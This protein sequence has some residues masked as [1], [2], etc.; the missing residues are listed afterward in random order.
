MNAARSMIGRP[1]FIP[2]LI[3]LFFMFAAGFLA[4]KEYLH[5]VNVAARATYEAGWSKVLPYERNPLS[6]IST[7]Y[8]WD[9][10]HPGA[11]CMEVYRYFH[12]E[13]APDFR[14][15]LASAGLAALSF[16]AVFMLPGKKPE[17]PVE[18]SLAKERD[19][20][21]HGYLG[22]GR[23]GEGAVFLGLWEGKPKKYVQ[24][25]P[26]ELARHV[27]VEAG[28]GE[29]KTTTYVMSLAM[30]AARNKQG[31]I[32][33]D[34]KYGEPSGLVDV[35][36]IFRYY[37]R[38]VYTY[39]PYDPD[40]PRI[41]LLDMVTDH[42]S[43]TKLAE[44]LIAPAED[45]SVD[46]YRG[47]ERDMFAAVALAIALT[48]RADGR[49]ARMSE[50]VKIFNTGDLKYVSEILQEGSRFSTEPKNDPW[51]WGQLI[52]NDEKRLRQVPESMRSLRTKL[53]VFLQDP[54]V[55]RATSRGPRGE[56][57]SLSAIFEDP[58]LLYIGLPKTEVVSETNK[59][60]MRMLKI[61]IDDGLYQ[62]AVENHGGELPYL[63]HYVLDEFQN[64]GELPRIFEALALF[65]SMRTSFHII[66]QDRAAVE[67][68]YG[69][70]GL[71]QLI[72]N[73][74]GTK[75]YYVGGLSDDARMELEERVGEKVIVEEGLMRKLSPTHELEARQTRRLGKKPVYS[76]EEMQRATQGTVLARL[77]YVPYVLYHAVLLDDPQHPLYRDWRS[78]KESAPLQA[79][80]WL[81][82]IEGVAVEG[83]NNARPKDSQLDRFTAWVLELLDAAAPLETVRARDGNLGMVRVIG[84][85][86]EALAD[87]W[88]ERGW[89]ARYRENW[90]ITRKGIE[91]LDSGIE[92]KIRGL[93][94]IRRQL[95]ALEDM[96]EVARGVVA[97]DN[98]RV[99][100][101]EPSRTIFVHVSTPLANK[102]EE[103][104]ADLLALGVKKP[105]EWR[106]LPRGRLAYG[107]IHE[108]LLQRGYGELFARNE[109]GGVSAR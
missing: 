11:N 99:I 10:K 32:A 28:T 58:S 96:G 18:G 108:D 29:G 93:S 12:Q 71:E 47:V 20:K 24:L 67:K 52:F 5:S 48:A 17:L 94:A 53:A 27:L 14:L 73:N 34:Q 76:V 51:E 36:S 1:L 81:E 7:C 100:V 39:A 65:R 30:S 62:A 92:E 85:S 80:E 26:G 43:A 83:G 19:L 70:S 2:L 91:L 75:I 37:G 44:A 77:H 57:L 15:P 33:W 8:A 66:I 60:L 31:F 87:E 13:Y 90:V 50:V 74:T 98:A 68:I 3:G 63:T 42:K 89:V 101:D 64:F 104:P 106:A 46:F 95:Q 22:D 107:Q 59:T 103:K 55:D 45:E 6:F 21:K 88:V 102:G 84:L 49:A 16:L 72:G 25:P 9:V 61:W 54:N 82:R 40:T 78:I 109:G 79:S 41:P 105:D 4:L 69:T 38:P 97:Q 23:L 56:N 86:R 35:L